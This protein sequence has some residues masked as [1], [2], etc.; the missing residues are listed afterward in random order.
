MPFLM[1]ARSALC[2]KI[3][4]RCEFDVLPH[5]VGVDAHSRDD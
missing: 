3:R 1:R 4:P 5:A 2:E